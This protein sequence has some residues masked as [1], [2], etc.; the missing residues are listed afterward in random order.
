MDLALWRDL[1]III[2]GV[3]GTIALVFICVIAYL[4]FRRTISLIE[5]ADTVVAKV[6]DIVNYAEKEVIRPVSQF[7][8]MIQGIVQGVDLFK[9]V[10]RK[11]EDDDE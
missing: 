3:I 11:K 5:S 4:F 8:A 6:S 2:W 1:V 10:F 9:N 7:G